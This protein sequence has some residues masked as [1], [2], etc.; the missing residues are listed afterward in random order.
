MRNK[1]WGSR[2]ND[3]LG[4]TCK[5]ARMVQFLSSI[6]RQVYWLLEQGECWAH[7][8]KL[9]LHSSTRLNQQSLGL[10]P[11]DYKHYVLRAFWINLG[12]IWGFQ[13]VWSN[14]VLELNLGLGEHHWRSFSHKSWVTWPLASMTRQIRWDSQDFKQSLEQVDF[15]SSLETLELRNIGEVLCS[16]ASKTNLEVRLG[17]LCVEP[18][19]LICIELISD[20]ID[21]CQRK[22]LVG[23]W[24]VASK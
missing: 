19:C 3:N 2:T 15:P 4:V 14:W 10:T 18:T 23:I 8:S 6:P 22:I 21:P 1:D 7:S 13:M 12:C 20:L 17:F 9:C 11:S 5:L 16:W 24:L